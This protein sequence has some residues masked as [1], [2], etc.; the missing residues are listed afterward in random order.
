[1]SLLVYESDS[2]FTVDFNSIVDLLRFTIVNISD[3]VFF[4]FLTV[5]FCTLINKRI[6]K[7]IN[8]TGIILLCINQFIMLKFLWS[9]EF[10]EAYL[11]VNLI[12]MLGIFA[13]YLADIVLFFVIE[14]ESEQ[15]YFLS[16]INMVRRAM[17]LE[18]VRYEALYERQ[19]ELAKLRHDYNNQLIVVQLLLE[20]GNEAEARE[21][22]VELKSRLKAEEI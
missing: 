19:Q 22:A 15:E 17:E 11:A 21:I 16:E 12:S 18:G 6:T 14:S 1:M 5:P 7:K 3:V 2:S 13:G 9:V 8:M 10:I 4:L 20:S